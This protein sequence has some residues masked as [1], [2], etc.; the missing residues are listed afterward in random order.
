VIETRQ[1]EKL[2]LKVSARESC[3][4]LLMIVKIIKILLINCLGYLTGLIL[5]NKRVLWEGWVV[6]EGKN[7]KVGGMGD[8]YRFFFGKYKYSL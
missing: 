3:W 8:L 4:S 6:R 5:C 7:I 2:L 1:L